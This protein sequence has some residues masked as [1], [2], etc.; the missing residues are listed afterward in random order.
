MEGG[1][2]P[3]PAF[4]S[5]RTLLCAFHHITG[6][7]RWTAGTLWCAADADSLPAARRTSTQIAK[8]SFVADRLP[9]QAAHGASSVN[10][11]VDNL[12]GVSHELE[13]SAFGGDIRQ[14][15]KVTEVGTEMRGLF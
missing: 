15:G 14:E 11:V 3:T 12:L 1:E 6:G 5:P 7:R 8:R 9:P 2:P 13:D 10:P 4:E